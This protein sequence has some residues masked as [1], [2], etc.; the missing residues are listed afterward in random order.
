MVAS[1]KSCSDFLWTRRVNQILFRW[2][3]W[4][5]WENIWDATLFGERIWWYPEFQKILKMLSCP[6]LSLFYRFALFAKLFLLTGGIW[7]LRVVLFILQ[8]KGLYLSWYG[9]MLEIVFSVPE[10]IFPMIVFHHSE[11]IKWC[12]NKAPVISSEY[13]KIIFLCIYL[14]YISNV[15]KYLL[16]IE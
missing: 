13:M 14:T 6:F 9:V 15:F 16:F 3:K 4:H 11:F 10:V 1:E 5:C 2:Y 12:W 8:V 7:L